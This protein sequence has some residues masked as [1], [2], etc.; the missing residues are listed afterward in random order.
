MLTM[1]KPAPTASAGENVASAHANPPSNI[2]IEIDNIDFCYGA[3][4][5]LHGITLDV[6]KNKVTALIGPSGCGK[7]TLLRCLNRMNDLVP[8]SFVKSGQI[9]IHGMD[10]YDSEVDVIE[11]RKRV[12]MVLQ[13]SNPFP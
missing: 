1:D 11:L 3:Y 7:T 5:A 9:R 4:Q 6:P 2:A 10:I 13:K 12:G 8:E